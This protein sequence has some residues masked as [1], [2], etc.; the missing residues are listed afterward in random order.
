M[1]C[2]WESFS[3]ATVLPKMH[4]LEEVVVPWLRRWH[5]GFGML[6]EQGAERIHAYFNSLGRTYI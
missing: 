4:I 6:E 3:T 1:K 2:Y 5:I